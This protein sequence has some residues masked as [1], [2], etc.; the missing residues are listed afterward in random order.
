MPTL[1]FLFALLFASFTPA[2][3]TALGKNDQ[4]TSKVITKGKPNNG[5]FII[6]EDTH[7]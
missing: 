7:P 3:T 4:K 6:G 2:T 5:D 1:A